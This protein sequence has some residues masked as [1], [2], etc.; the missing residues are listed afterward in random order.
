MANVS[1]VVP[2]SE[3]LL[4]PKV[5]VIEGGIATVRFAVAVLPVPPFV[6]VTFPVV[7]VN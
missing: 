5:F 4:T 1:D 7:F 2:F 6:E 3:M